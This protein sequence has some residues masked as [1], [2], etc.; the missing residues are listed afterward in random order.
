[1][2]MI[3]QT[4]SH[5]KI[6]SKL[7]EGGMGVVYKAEDL[8]L[9]RFV[10]LKFLPSSIGDDKTRQ[11]FTHEAQAVSMLEH[12]NICSIYEIDESPEGRT[13]IVMPCYEGESLQARIARGPLKLEEAI[14]IT[15]QVA[16]GLARAHEKGVIHRD[17]KPANILITKDGPKIVDFGLA[18]LAAQ[19]KLT[20]T[21]TTVGTTMYMS[22]EQARGQETDRR[23]DIWS[24]G[25]V[26]Y[27]MLTGRPPFTGEHEAA[28]L[29]QIINEEPQ[30]VTGVRTGVPMELERIV[31]K[32]IA[33][34]AAE[35]Y[36]HA[37]DV[38]ADLRRLAG[39]MS[40]PAA[41][42]P[43][44]ARR[45][46]PRRTALR[47]LWI[48]AFVVMLAGVIAVVLRYG[49]PSTSSQVAERKMVTVLPFE[50]LGAAE[51]EYFAAG[52]TEEIT[53][54]LA[55]IRELGVT[56]RTSALQYAGTKKTVKEI[57][58]ELGVGY[59]LEGTVRWARKRGEAS[60]VRITP[61][62]IRVSDDTHLWSDTYDR[63]MEDIFDIQSDIAQKVVEHLGLA[64][65]DKKHPAIENRATENLEAYQA[66]LQARYWAGQ[67]HFTAENWERAIQSYERAVEID[68][69]FALA[70]A[71]LSI[72]HGRLYYYLYDLS[73][74][75]REKT[76]AAVEEAARLGPG[77]P[78]VHIALG[79]YHLL[80]ERDAQ[81]AFGEFEIAARD[82]PD[83]ADVLKAKGDCFREEGRW[84]EAIEHYRRACQLDPRSG[85][86][87]VDLAECH[88]FTRR[89]PEADEECNKAIAFAP[90][91]MWPY[92]TKAFNAWSWK[93]APSATRAILE[94]MPAE[95]R[96]EW[97]DWAWFRQCLLEQRY[98]EALDRIAAISG[99]WI[100]VKIDAEPVSMMAAQVY[101]LLGD[102]RRARAEYETARGQLE[103]EVR[104][105]PDDPRY[106]SS[107]GVSYAA[108]GQ[109]DE[110][111]REGKRGAELLPLTKD[112]VYG[113]PGVIALAHIYTLIGDHRAA[114]EQL[115]YLLSV[116][117]WI[118]PAWLKKDPRWNRLRDDPEFQR[119]LVKHETEK[120]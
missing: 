19:T 31:A 57:G 83:D 5:Y 45:Q 25:T 23:S 15:G 11:R 77:V 110:G 76:K 70:Y 34:D 6:L 84:L 64:L 46:A 27:E 116:P 32:C 97:V 33:K 12:P 68:P 16:S 73:P 79:Y 117:S 29:Y 50:N 90:D 69:K 105:H 112:A 106:H 78:Q 38:V 3:G 91:Q 101:E 80:V 44:G 48:A 13:F 71:G 72:A 17:I 59:V 88:W 120:T 8:K 36:H 87:W 7:G 24:L 63:V 47:W 37:D 95:I 75:R 42:R 10:A 89:Y 74:E 54:R 92:L 98:Q 26:L 58:A 93:E 102:E 62:L 66:Y 52:I 111:I 81:R 60:K 94:S 67:P 96:D 51:D 99:G 18:K 108:L 61:Q 22:P 9:H 113:L 53:S 118:S 20:K 107:L 119:L 2:D 35:R 65:L 82:L 39:T 114:L 43:T 55:T 56:S 100:R 1:M 85:S 103:A 115:E 86:L 21:R 104:A 28:V 41:M 40:S 109:R 30:P 14:E 4:I 49:G